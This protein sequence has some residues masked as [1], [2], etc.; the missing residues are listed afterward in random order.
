MADPGYP[1]GA[2]TKGQPEAAVQAGEKL[3]NR[4][5][6]RLADQAAPIFIAILRSLRQPPTTADEAGH[7]FKAILRSLRQPRRSV[8]LD[9]DDD[10]DKEEEEEEEEMV[11]SEEELEAAGISLGLGLTAPTDDA[12]ALCQGLL[13]TPQ[14]VPTSSL[15]D[16]GVFD[17]I[18]RAAAGYNEAAIVQLMTP[19]IIPFP[20]L[21][22]WRG[23]QDLEGLAQSYNKRWTHAQPLAGY[24][25]Q[26]DLSVGLG[27]RA[28]TSPQLRKLHRLRLSATDGLYFPFLVVE[29]KCHRGS[30][31]DADCQGVH[32][33]SVAANTLVQLYRAISRQHELHREILAFSVSHDHGNVRIWAH[34]AWIDGAETRFYRHPIHQCSITFD[35]GRGRWTPYKFLRSVYD[36]FAPVHMARIRS[37]LD[38]MPEERSDKQ[39]MD[40]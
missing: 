10:D 28:F 7:I 5:S 27:H 24:Q 11:P 13:D 40:D 23:A 29:V 19:C 15:F 37:A 2:P 35:H 16:D 3:A 26:P 12:K 32:G 31:E 36:A 39:L 4:A 8:G 30:L 38:T 34:Y 20:Q 22:F 33:A 25:P 17:K 14:P 1:A 18:C 6:K 21:L 9:D